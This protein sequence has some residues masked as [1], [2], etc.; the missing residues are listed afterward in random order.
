MGGTAQYS[1]K[2]APWIKTVK[3]PA[4]QPIHGLWMIATDV[5][6]INLKTL[7]YYGDLCESI[8]GWCRQIHG[9]NQRCDIC[10]RDRNG[11]S[12][13][14]VLIQ[15]QQYKK[16]N[17]KTTHSTNWNWNDRFPGITE[18]DFEGRKNTF[19]F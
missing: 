7:A 17:G 8:I 19:R 1:I 12:L 14:V 10:I 16:K 3:V 11:K 5:V 2:T 6:Y 9:K 18:N 15:L 4:F 13:L